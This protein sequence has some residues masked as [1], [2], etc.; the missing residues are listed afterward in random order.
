MDLVRNANYKG[1]MKHSIYLPKLHSK[2]PHSKLH[3]KPHQ[4]VVKDRK[5]TILFFQS[6]KFRVMGCVDE[7]DAM[8]LVYKYSNLI[9]DDEFPPVTLQS[10]TSTSHLGYRVNLEKMAATSD[11]FGYEPELFSA[12]R[13]REFNPASVN[14]FTTGRV[15]VCGLRDAEQMYDIMIK[16]HEICK[17]FHY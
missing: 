3:K 5:G 1:S 11:A 13:I 15:I 4:L 6:G 7:L 17:P 2:I 14:I 12:L 10:Y 16:L 9:N 8:F